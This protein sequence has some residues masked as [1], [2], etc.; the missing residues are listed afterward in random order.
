MLQVHIAQPD[1]GARVVAYL[2]SDEAWLITGNVIHL[3]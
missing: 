1:D 2:V 3:R